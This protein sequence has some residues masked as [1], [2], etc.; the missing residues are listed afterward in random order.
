M[1]FMDDLA[2]IVQK[3]G[4]LEVVGF[5]TGKGLIEGL[6]LTDSL[7]DISATPLSATHSRSQRSTWTLNVEMTDALLLGCSA[8][9]VTKA[10]FQ[11]G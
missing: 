11:D 3:L 5:T 4:S 2:E 1:L 8:S 9:S 10:S 6:T 7:L